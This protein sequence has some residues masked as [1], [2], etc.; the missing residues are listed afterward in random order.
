MALR[1]IWAGAALAVL[2]ACGDTGVE[3]ELT[4]GEMVEANAD[5]AERVA[6]L[7][8]T[9][10]RDMPVRGSSTFDGYAALTMQTERRTDLV[11]TARLT[12]D[13]ED[14]T[15]RGSLRDFQGRVNG[16]GVQDLEGRLRLSDGDIGLATAS[17]FGA[18]LDGELTAE[19]GRVVGVDGSVVGNFRSEDGRGAQAL[20]AISGR[21]TDFTLNGRERGG[22][23]SIV[24]ER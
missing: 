18:D 7:P 3:D 22:V 14:Q 23:L 15:I 19:N 21:G 24:A 16:S 11:G 13:F 9:R 4:F 6:G 2:S 12:A 17:A 5:M 1:W 20:T 8:S 10:A